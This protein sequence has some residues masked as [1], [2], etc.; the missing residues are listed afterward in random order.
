MHA[1]VLLI[2]VTP[3]SDYYC[4]HVVI[5]GRNDLNHVLLISLDYFQI[6]LF[7]RKQ[8]LDAYF[9][10]FIKM[11]LYW[12]ALLCVMLCRS[13]VIVTVIDLLKY[14]S[15]Y[16]RK[17]VPKIIN[18]FPCKLGVLRRIFGIVLVTDVYKRLVGTYVS[19]RKPCYHLC[20]E[21]M[22]LLHV[23]KP[24]IFADAAEQQGCGFLVNIKHR[25]TDQWM[26]PSIAGKRVIYIY[27]YMYVCIYI[28]IYMYWTWHYTNK[29]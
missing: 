6:Y 23:G 8:Q 10:Y 20:F 9:T 7:L 24:V 25:V 15:Q 16:I 14:I 21:F 5:H 2:Y 28:H 1:D 3:V 27:T 29:C 18:V 22:V 17:R 13:G 11:S 4:V 26:W 19:C 12:R